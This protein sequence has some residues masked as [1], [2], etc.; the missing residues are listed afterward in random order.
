[1]DLYPGFSSCLRCPCWLLLSCN[2]H[3]CFLTIERLLIKAEL[4]SVI[5]KESWHD[6]SA[7]GKPRQPCA[8]HALTTS[9]T[10]CFPALLG[11]L[12]Y[13]KQ[14]TSITGFLKLPEKP[15]GS[16]GSI[17]LITTQFAA[18]RNFKKEILNTISHLWSPLPSRWASHHRK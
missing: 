8:T 11:C 16:P 1:M 9:Q 6:C 3:L 7:Q 15:L 10:Q 2:M 14:G 12:S 4:L 5:W 17:V 13:L 18:Y